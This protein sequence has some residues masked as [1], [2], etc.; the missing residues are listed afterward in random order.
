MKTKLGE[1]LPFMLRQAQHERL[2][3]PVTLSLSK[4]DRFVDR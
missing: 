3:N 4:G 2:L 1:N